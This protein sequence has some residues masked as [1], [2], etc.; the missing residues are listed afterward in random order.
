MLVTGKLKACCRERDRSL[1][2]H[3]DTEVLKVFSLKHRLTLM[4]LPLRDKHHNLDVLKM[5]CRLIAPK[6]LEMSSRQNLQYYCTSHLQ[7]YKGIIHYFYTSETPGH[8]RRA[9]QSRCFLDL[10]VLFMLVPLCQKQ[11][12]NIKRRENV[13]CTM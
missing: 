2:S 5:T 3:K 6:I 8:V 1:F 12:E 13:Y 11:K 9:V 4:F 7:E 10:C